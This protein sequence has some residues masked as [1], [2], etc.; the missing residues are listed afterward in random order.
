MHGKDISNFHYQYADT[1]ELLIQ[2]MQNAFLAE[3]SVIAHTMR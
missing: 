3:L 1:M 2:E